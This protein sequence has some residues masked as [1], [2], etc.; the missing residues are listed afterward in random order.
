LAEF[1]NLKDGIAEEELDRVKIG[2][3]SALIMRQ[4]STGGRS[5]AL[6]ADWYYLGRIRP[7]DEIQAAVNGLTVNKIL[8]YLERHPMQDFTVVT[9]GPSALTV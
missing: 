1:R 5:S 9:L 2:L 7:L 4:E 6:S 8:G 3:K